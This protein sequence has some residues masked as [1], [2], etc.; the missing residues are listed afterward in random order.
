[1]IYMFYNRG[2]VGK[3]EVNGNRFSVFRR[4][5]YRAETLYFSSQ[6]NLYFIYLKLYSDM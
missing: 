4:I 1:M 3:H 5:W 2:G 6:I